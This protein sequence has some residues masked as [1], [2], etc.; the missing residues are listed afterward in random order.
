MQQDFQVLSSGSLDATRNSVLRNTYR[1]LGIS[2]LP[3][4]LGAAVGVNTGFSFLAGSPILGMILMMAVVYGLMFA[5]E[6]NKYSATGVYLLLAFTF[7]M[8]F[9]LGPILQLSLH[10]RNGAQ[11]IGVAA[12][13]TGLIFLGMS[14]LGS[15]AKRNFA[16]MGQFLMVGAVVLLVAM[17]ANMFLQLPAL[18][19]TIAAAFMVFSSL[20]ISFQVN[21]IVR[22][23]ETNYISA[24]LSIYISIYNIFVS[25]LQ[26]LLAFAG[27]NRR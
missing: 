26:L 23:G 24:A 7:V 19:L 14:T 11:L 18:Q 20:M 12:G 25:L 3:T 5:I 9:L 1:L 13:G 2:M 8:G 22:G 27:D 4:A 15:N 17:L 10:M 6:R 16:G 21:A